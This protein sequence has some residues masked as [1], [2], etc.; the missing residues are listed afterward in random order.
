MADEKPKTDKRLEL[1]RKISETA[2]EMTMQYLE[3]LNKTINNNDLTPK[4]GIKAF[5][6]MDKVLRIA[7]LFSDR[8]LLAEGKATENIG[9][10]GMD[11]PFS[12]LITKTY[13]SKEKG[14]D[15]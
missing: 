12:V 6:E 11:R 2:D 1:V 5:C 10:G 14:T 3:E 4:D 13:A 9:V 15:D 7:K 8:V